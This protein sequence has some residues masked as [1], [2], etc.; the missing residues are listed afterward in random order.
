MD[1]QT[2][3]AIIAA[4]YAA[5]GPLP[6]VSDTDAYAEHQA[7]VVEAIATITV[8]SEDEE[9][10]AN[11]AI[12][13]VTPG[14]NVKRFSG[15]IE[16]VTKEEAT[17]RGVVH[18]RTRVHP[19]YAPDG[20]E[21]VRTE[22][23]DNPVGLSMAKRLRSLRGHKVLMWVEIESFTNRSGANRKS[24]V[25]RFCRDLGVPAE[26]EGEGQVA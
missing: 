2:R 26:E 8:T 12:D 20:V 14:P 6:D 9:S 15:V 4:A 11:K 13:Q 16:K 21:K 23:T 24:R 19:E 10:F 7:K 17:T 18:I 25:V 3:T 1:A 5:A 22:R